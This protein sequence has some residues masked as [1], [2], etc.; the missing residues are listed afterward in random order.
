MNQPPND[1][2]FLLPDLGEGLAE[3]QICEWLI[4][5]DQVIRQDQEM[6]LVETA[7]SVMSIPAPYS[8]QLKQIIAP[9][10]TTISVGQPICII[11]SQVAKKN[12]QNPSMKTH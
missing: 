7:K 9:Q 3:A 4:Q 8:G 1:I 2:E 11:S 12:P 5:P 10:G 6:V